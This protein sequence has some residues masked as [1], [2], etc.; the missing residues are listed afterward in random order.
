VA[1]KCEVVTNKL[2][3]GADLSFI[4]GK[5]TAHFQP[6]QPLPRR[7]PWMTRIQVPTGCVNRARIISVSPLARAETA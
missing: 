5:P 4:G 2:N 1:G 7:A 3:A 6:W